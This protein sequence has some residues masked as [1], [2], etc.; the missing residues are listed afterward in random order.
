MFVSLAAFPQ[1]RRAECF[2]PGIILMTL[3]LA[4]VVQYCTVYKF[5]RDRKDS[6]KAFAAAAVTHFVAAAIYVSISPR[7][8]QLHNSRA[9]IVWYVV[10]AVE[11]LIQL[12]LAWMFDVLAI[13]GP[14][15]PQRLA[16][17]TVMILGE[18]VAKIGKNIFLIGENDGEPWSE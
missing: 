14:K 9:H 5:Y 16:T 15:L 4:L 2:L 12:G 6:K 8:D 3:R 11:A 1:P 18:G 13:K 7:F 10:S 17:L